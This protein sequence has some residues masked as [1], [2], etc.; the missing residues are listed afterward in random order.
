[1]LT[2]EFEWDDY[3][4]SENLQKHGID[5]LDAIRI[6]LNPHRLEVED[7]REEYG[8]HRFKTI[9]IVQDRVIVVVY[10]Y[11]QE[12]IRIISARKAEPYE[13]RKYHEGETGS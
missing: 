3:K 5:F 7:D 11:L 6:F 13:R 4:V 2:M 9:G 10:T 8:E 12:R 1:M